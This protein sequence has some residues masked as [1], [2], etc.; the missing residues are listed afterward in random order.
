MIFFFTGLF[1]KDSIHENEAVQ[2]ILPM[3][4]PAHL[5]SRFTDTDEVIQ[6]SVMEL[7]LRL[8]E[9]LS[10]GYVMLPWAKPDQI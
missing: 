1:E 9:L 2:R 3:K 6:Q 10:S 4:T 8:D 7:E 5:L